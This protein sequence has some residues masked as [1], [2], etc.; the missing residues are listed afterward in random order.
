MSGDGGAQ[1][2]AGMALWVEPSPVFRGFSEQLSGNVQGLP[3]LLVTGGRGGQLFPCLPGP[4]RQELP[5][6]P[7]PR[8]VLSEQCGQFPA[9]QCV[10]PA[11]SLGADLCLGS[12]LP[13]TRA[14]EEAWRGQGRSRWEINTGVHSPGL[15]YAARIFFFPLIFYPSDKGVIFWLHRFKKATKSGILRGYK[16]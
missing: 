6:L 8:H 4:V 7:G 2:L 15:L 10:V 12:P 11:S 16:R 14:G 3:V 9:R 13:V 1:R 5:R